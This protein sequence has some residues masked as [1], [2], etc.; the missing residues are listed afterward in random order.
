MSSVRLRDD[1]S[2]QRD[3]D[4]FGDPIVVIGDPVVRRFFAL[5][6]EA[7]PVLDQLRELTELAALVASFADAFDEAELDGLVRGL[8]ANHLLDEGLPAPTLR[9]RLRA[10]HRAEQ[11]SALQRTLR[12]GERVPIYRQKFRALGFDPGVQ[13]GVPPGVPTEAELV[14]APYL[15]K[16]DIKEHY[17]SGFVPDGT[18][19]D[20]MIGTRQVRLA[21][22]SGTSAGDRLQMI[23]SADARGL[24][25]AAG[26]ALNDELHRAAKLPQAVLTSMHC[27]DPDVCVRYQPEMQ[28]RIRDGNRLLLI[29][30]DDPGA[31]TL[32]EVRTIFAELRGFAVHWLDCNPTYLMNVTF[33]AIDAGL[34]LPRIGV[35][36]CG[37]EFLSM[38]H[39]AA[40]E[41]A[42][43]CEVYNRYTASEVGNFQMI[44]C[45]R[46]S[47][48]LNDRYFYSELVRDGRHVGPGEV[49]RLVQTT[50]Q[51]MI[52]LIRYDTGDLFVA[53]EDRDCGCGN[54]GRI[55]AAI[56]GRACDLVTATD[57]SPRT[58]RQ[59]D[60][61]LGTVDGLRSYQV[62]QTAPTA[63]RVKAVAE[64]GREVSSVR[65]CAADA[66]RAVLG[67]DAHVRTEGARH[68]YPEPSG[69]FRLTGSE[70][71]GLDRLI[72]VAP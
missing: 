32:S 65:A 50:L 24:Q 22:S 23:F 63:Y 72:S 1:L 27:A 36:T 47:L 4:R 68:I 52:P 56:A 8:A 35:I 55:V 15:T 17:P 53:E 40:L 13:P 18:D 33:A 60:A 57:G 66:V 51:E 49:G 44:E 6:A 5:P 38:L 64:P 48:H 3:V 39:R 61:A 11:W 58:T 41:R 67:A 19:L 26:T 34:E 29:P 14:H 69:K 71:P 54:V 59:I 70:L 30:P 31:P 12:L 28:S 16:L 45:H 2:L 9:A 20:E 37:Y 10:S 43:G 42:W 7:E 62:M 25:M 21:T 46:H